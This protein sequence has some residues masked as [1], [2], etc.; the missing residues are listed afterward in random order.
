MTP[1]PLTAF[2]PTAW[3]AAMSEEDRIHGVIET[4][5]SSRAQIASARIHSKELREALLQ[6]QELILD[7]QARLRACDKVMSRWWYHSEALRP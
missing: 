5:Q 6:T 1:G 7:S 4:L 2:C 3:K